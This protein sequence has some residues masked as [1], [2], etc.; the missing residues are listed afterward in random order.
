MRLLNMVVVT[1]LFFVLGATLPAVAQE[2]PKDEAKPASHQEEAKPAKH[3]EEA[4]PAPRQE[5]GKPAPH[6]SEARPAGRQDEMKPTTRPEEARP[7]R[8]NEPAHQMQGGNPQPTPEQRQVHQTT[9]QSH[10]AQHWQT[11]HRTWRQRGGYHG[12][13]IPQPRYQEYFGP[14]HVFAIYTVPIVVYGGYPRFQYGG[15]WFSVVDPWTEYWAADWFDNDD[16]YILYTDDGYYL[17]D[18]RYPGVLLAV[19]VAM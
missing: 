11:E 7:A 5:E 2:Q 10:R 9:W 1:L 12:Y 16:V 13:R 18:Q 14:S 19:D 6:P 15:F 4:K 17:V 8:Q 3:Q